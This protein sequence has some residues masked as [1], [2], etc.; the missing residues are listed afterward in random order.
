[1]PDSETCSGC[2]RV[3]RVQE[4]TY[5]RRLDKTSQERYPDLEAER[6]AWDAAKSR[7]RKAQLI[8]R[9]RAE[10]AAK[11]EKKAAEEQ[12][13]YKTVM[14]ARAAFARPSFLH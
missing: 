14:K 10:K 13:S 6:G 12:R 7:Q 8:E 9:Q 3:L 11:E 5:M 4:R 1:M 2:L